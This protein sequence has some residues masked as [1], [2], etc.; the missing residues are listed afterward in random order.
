ML[1]PD[2]S[3]ADALRLLS[4]PG[5]DDRGDRRGPG[6]WSRRGFLQAIGAG[7]IGGAALGTLGEMLVP[8]DLRDAFAAAPIGPTDGILITLMLYG[9]NDG[10]N[11]VVPYGNGLYYSQ[12]GNIAVPAAQVLLIS[13]DVCRSRRLSLNSFQQVDLRG[14]QWL[15]LGM[16]IS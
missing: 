13:A 12:R 14:P 2:I 7:V 15:W 9:G 3:T 4:T 11:T 10:L 8:G 1:D 16:R 5:L 6:G